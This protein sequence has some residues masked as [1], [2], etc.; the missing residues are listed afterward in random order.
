MKVPWIA[1]PIVLLAL[2]LSNP[3]IAQVGSRFIY[4]GEL[5]VAGEPANGPYDF[6][7][8]LYGSATGGITLAQRDIEDHPVDSGLFSLP[9]DFTDVPFRAGQRYWIE[10]RVRGGSET[11]PYTTLTPR[12]E[13]MPVPY[14]IHALSVAPA[15]VG[16]AEIVPGEVQRR[17]SGSCAAGSSIRAIAIDGTVTCE[18][19]D[20][21]PG[22]SGYQIVTT[23][24]TYFG[25]TPGT[26]SASAVVDCPSG[27]RVIGGGV[28][29][30][31][32]G[33]F[34]RRSS[35]R[36]DAF[37]SGWYGSVLKRG[38]SDCGVNPATMTVYAI[39]ANVN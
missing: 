31:C 27:K 14:A 12:R 18:I 29:A 33:A 24:R 5:R 36:D 22:F 19:D 10:L 7:A 3:A 21:S 39:C 32:A 2:L 38:D 13:L 23:Q 15:S 11:G 30:G 35:P 1:L 16:T 8:L 6:R 25:G 28:D 17:V 20:D 26:S 37:G 34:I 4:Q 9:I